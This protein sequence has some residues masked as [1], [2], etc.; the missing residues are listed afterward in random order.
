[1]SFVEPDYLK[2]K[3]DKMAN[4]LIISVSYAI[5]G[6]S[7]IF[8]IMARM[9]FWFLVIPLG[10]TETYMPLWL[11]VDSSKSFKYSVK[12]MRKFNELKQTLYGK[13][14]CVHIFDFRKHGPYW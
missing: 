7:L 11:D 1:M 3:T 14:K 8:Y 5:F 10:F 13:S 6:I 9:I 12:L 2:T 4:K